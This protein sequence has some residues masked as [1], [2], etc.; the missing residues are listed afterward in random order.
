M[1]N[2]VDAISLSKGDASEVELK[3]GFSQVKHAYDLGEK[4][5]VADYKVDAIEA[6]NAEHNM[7]VLEAV[8]AYPMA[9]F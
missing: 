3:G 9:F 5:H 2:P 6:E 1:S 8:R 4:V 7:S